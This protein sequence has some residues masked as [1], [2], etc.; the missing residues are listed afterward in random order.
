MRESVG[1]TKWTDT[2]TSYINLFV[3]L[4]PLFGVVYSWISLPHGIPSDDASLARWL[5]GAWASTRPTN[6]WLV[7][8]GRNPYQ[9]SISRP[10]ASVPAVLGEV[11]LIRPDKFTMT[12]DTVLTYQISSPCQF[13]DI[14]GGNGET[15]MRNACG[16]DSFGELR[17]IIFGGVFVVC[18]AFAWYW[19]RRWL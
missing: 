1:M 16:V 5:L 17:H 14:T 3:A 15:L 11:R 2:V 9:V 8:P 19:Y 13:K 18:L 12:Q 4:L 7:V 6:E 10:Y